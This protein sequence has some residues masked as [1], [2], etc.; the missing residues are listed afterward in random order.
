MDGTFFFFEFLVE[1]LHTFRS[2]KVNIE[3]GTNLLEKGEKK[4]RGKEIGKEMIIFFLP[5]MLQTR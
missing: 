5:R 4:E 2:T 3:G 1:L